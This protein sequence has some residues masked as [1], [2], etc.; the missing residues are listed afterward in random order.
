M[1]NNVYDMVMHF[2]LKYGIFH[3]LRQQPNLGE[4]GLEMNLD[5]TD[6]SMLPEF[7]PTFL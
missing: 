4:R 5:I 3:I 2:K 1:H 6:V 7:W